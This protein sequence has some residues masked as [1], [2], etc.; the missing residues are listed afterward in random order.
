[1]ENALSHWNWPK[2]PIMTLFPMDGVLLEVCNRKV[3]CRAWSLVATTS[4]IQTSSRLFFHDSTDMGITL[5]ILGSGYTTCLCLCESN[6]GPT[7]SLLP[8]IVKLYPQSS[9]CADYSGVSP[10]QSNGTIHHF[11]NFLSYYNL[12]MRFL[13][14]GEGCNTPCYKKPNP[15]L[16]Y[17]S[18]T[19]MQD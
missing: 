7:H 11:L 1:M 12:G 16:N 17:I 19:L 4:N 10:S 5:F 6:V 3:N 14:R 18:Q 9:L 8:V 13:L 15:F 2:N